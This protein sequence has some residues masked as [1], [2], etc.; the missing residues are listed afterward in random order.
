MYNSKTWCE[1]GRVDN[2]EKE[3]EEWR[4]SESQQKIPLDA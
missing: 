1:C 2:E 4:T 3:V